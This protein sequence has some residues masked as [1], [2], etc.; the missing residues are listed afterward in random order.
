MMCRHLQQFAMLC[1]PLS[2]LDMAVYQ[3]VRPM[4]C[5]AV[6]DASKKDQ[7][8]PSEHILEWMANYV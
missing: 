1:G 6:Q 8:H 5:D 2:L 7:L 4:T 3:F